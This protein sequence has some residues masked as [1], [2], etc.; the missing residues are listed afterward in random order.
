MLAALTIKM[1]SNCMNL[2]ESLVKMSTQVLNIKKK[3]IKEREEEN[4][5]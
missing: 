4:F 5:C 3:Y 1:G 2:E